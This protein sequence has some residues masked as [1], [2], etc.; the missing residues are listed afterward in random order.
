M[1]DGEGGRVALPKATAQLLTWTAV[2]AMARYAPMH[3]ASS[4]SKMAGLTLRDSPWGQGWKNG[5]PHR[6]WCPGLWPT[7]HL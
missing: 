5:P 2:Y 3:K 7:T 1:R 4:R 6:L